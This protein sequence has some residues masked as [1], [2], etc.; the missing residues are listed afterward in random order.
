MNG[1]QSPGTGKNRQFPGL[2]ALGPPHPRRGFAGFR[3][4]LGCILD[5][6]P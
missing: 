6:V 1:H 5:A 4:S 2:S 3:R